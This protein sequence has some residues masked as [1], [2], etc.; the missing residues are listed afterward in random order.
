MPL[1]TKYPNVCHLIYF[2][3]M[4][5]CRKC[6]YH[7]YRSLPPLLCRQQWIQQRW[8][9][10]ILWWL[11]GAQIHLVCFWTLYKWNH[12]IYSFLLKIFSPTNKIVIDCYVIYVFVMHPLH[13]LFFF[14]FLLKKLRCESC[15][16]PGAWLA[17]CS[18]NV[19]LDVWPSLLLPA[20]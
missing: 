18:L 8:R 9:N 20:S 19:S 5:T 3:Q 16:S 14:E 4:I 12:T 6:T 11:L 17:D 2:Q 10:R 13:L 15:E 7:H 1:L